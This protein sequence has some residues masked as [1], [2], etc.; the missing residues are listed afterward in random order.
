[1][2]Q[3]NALGDVVENAYAPVMKQGSIMVMPTASAETT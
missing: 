1:M 3:M 2:A